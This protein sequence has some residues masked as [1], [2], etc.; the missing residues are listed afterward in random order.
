[1]NISFEIGPDVI[2]SYRRLAYTPWHA[3][4]EFLDNSTQSYFNNRPVLDEAYKQAGEKL[5]IRVVYDRD[6]D[7][8]RISDNAMG[9][10]L[11]DLRDS[12]KL[13]KA[14]TITSGRSQYGLG[15]KTGACWLGDEWTVTTKKLG[16]DVEHRVTVNVEAVAN[17]Q[18]DLPYSE[19]PKPKDL[20]YTVVEI[21][22]LHTKLQGRRLGKIKEF[23]RSMYRVDIRENVMD[24]F[25]QGSPLEWS[26]E[27]EF[28]KAED[29]TPYWRTFDFQVNGKRVHGWVGILGQGAS[30]RPRAGFSILRR[31]R[32]IKGHP[33]AWRPESIFGQLQGSNDLIN[34]RITGEV[35]LDEFLVSHTK[36]DIQW[37]G[38]E[39]DEV[40][41]RL[42]EV[43]LDYVRTARDSRRTQKDKRGPTETE[44]QTAVDEL[45]TEM[46]SQEFVDII[47]VEEV[48]PPEAI[49]SALDPVLKAAER[50]EPR[51][52]ATVGDILC[53]VYLSYDNSPNDPYFA[54]DVTGDR[55]LV[56]VNCS[57]PHWAQLQGSEGVLNYLR[58][59]VYDAIAEWQC[60]RKGASLQ[61]DT[62]KMLKDRLLR[63]PSEIE[64]AGAESAGS[65][66]VN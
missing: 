26:D 52:D 25:W 5:G 57:H 17:G 31:G 41:D 44:V 33:D 29:G 23:L 13:G 47:D 4:A 10:D 49:K 27:S 59:C 3:L 30:G 46:L 11:T 18:G 9:M 7:L 58:H 1:M 50:A 32:V 2:R 54:T 51:F 34:Q 38:N 19:T 53:K 63:L 21:R 37:V 56:V 36:D 15:L 12:L 42:K 60:R 61:P 20:H 55:I 24:L 45:R 39:E 16:E 48:P 22:K 64:Q 40:Q 14:P 65:G 43:S 66:S 62:I 8:L 35:N 28:L 6:N